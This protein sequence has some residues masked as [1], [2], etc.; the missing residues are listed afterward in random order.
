[1]PRV[2]DPWEG[3]IGMSCSFLHQNSRLLRVCGFMVLDWPAALPQPNK[4]DAVMLRFYENPHFYP[5]GSLLPGH[6]PGNCTI[7]KWHLT[8]RAGGA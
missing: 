1:M 5:R 3:P 7:M 6:I 2:D 8:W 4:P